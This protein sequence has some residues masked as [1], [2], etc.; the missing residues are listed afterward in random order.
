M[1]ATHEDDQLAAVPPIVDRETWHAARDEL[2][3][4]E[5]AHM[6]A[7]DAITAARRRLSTLDRSNNIRTPD[8]GPT[9]R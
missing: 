3:V 9:D 7:G 2:L 6:R 5:K 4:R 1:T 8:R